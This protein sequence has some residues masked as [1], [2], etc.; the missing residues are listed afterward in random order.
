MNVIECVVFALVKK[1][2]SKKKERAN[3][4]VVVLDLF[5]PPFG[6]RAGKQGT[7]QG[8]TLSATREAEKGRR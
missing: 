8:K 1:Q 6:A 5:L 7:K 3:F 2:K 4:H